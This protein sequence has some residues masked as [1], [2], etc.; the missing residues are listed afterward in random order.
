MTLA[1]AIVPWIFF[2][3]SLVGDLIC[4]Q[5]FGKVPEVICFL[6]FRSALYKALLL[7]VI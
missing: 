6:L 3:L 1:S 4:G 5:G 7:P 2:R